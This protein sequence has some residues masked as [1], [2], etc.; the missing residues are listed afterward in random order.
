MP[1]FQRGRKLEKIG[2]PAQDTSE[3]FFEDV[4]IPAVNLLGTEG[5]GLRH[6]MSHLPRERLGVSVK[7]M[8]N[9]HVIFEETR[10]YCFERRA[11]GRPIV[12][13]QHARFKLAEMATEIDVA[14][15]YVGKC[16]RDS[17]RAP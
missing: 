8:A 2:L 16:V 12:D 4:R 9:C 6:L 11:F 13:F 14:Q 15:A 3:L 7:A 5:Q 1:G 17:T 10:R